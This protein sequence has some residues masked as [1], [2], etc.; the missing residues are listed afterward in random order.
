MNSIPYKQTNFITSGDQRE[1]QVVSNVTDLKKKNTLAGGQPSHRKGWGILVRSKEADAR[2]RR[3]QKEGIFH[4]GGL[5]LLQHCVRSTWGDSSLIYS[6]V[7][8]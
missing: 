7:S 4:W 3:N 6:T 8:Q 5:S 1:P 2:D